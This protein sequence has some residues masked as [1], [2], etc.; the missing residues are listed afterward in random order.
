VAEALESA[1]GIHRLGSV[2]IEAAG[3]HV[4][5][6]LP[7]R[8][9]AHVFHQHQLGRREAVVDLGHAHFRA[10]VLHAG[11]LVRVLRAGDDLREGREVV[12]LAVEALGRTGGER[13]RLQEDRMLRVLVRV[14][15]AAEDRRRGA[16][17]HARAVEDAEH[18]GDRR[19]LL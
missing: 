2:T 18:A 13:Q 15:G 3:E 8:R 14:L 9:E 4:L 5:P 19:R 7:A 6:P 16:V 10:R 12:V 17:A 1:V 11:L